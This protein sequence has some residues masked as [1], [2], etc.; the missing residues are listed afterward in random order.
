MSP[1][2]KERPQ[3]PPPEEMPLMMLINELSRLF[4]NHMRT[5][6]EKIG[7]QDGFRQLLFQLAHED[8]IPQLDLVQRTHLRAPTV[9]VALR[10]M[11]EA[12]LV[13]RRPSPD[14]Q[15]QMLVVLTDRGRELDR[16]QQEKFHEAEAL[17]ARGLAE[18]EYRQLKSLLLHMRQNVLAQ[19]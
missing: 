2:Q 5:E 1:V 19:L 16:R 14:D 7:V 6:S 11:E 17:F 18:D 13:S 4:R 8:N 9:S 3:A 10:Q 12:G 15:R